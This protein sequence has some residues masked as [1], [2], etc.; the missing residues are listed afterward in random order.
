M[1]DMAEIIL[2]TLVYQLVAY[3]K[4]PYTILVLLNIAENLKRK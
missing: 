1:S 3:Q 2:Q 4:A